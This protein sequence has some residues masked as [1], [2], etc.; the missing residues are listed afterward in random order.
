MKF[1]YEGEN[2]KDAIVSFMKNPSQPAEKSKEP[3][4]SEMESEVVHLTTANFD[5]YLASESSV[6]I[7]FYAPW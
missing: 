5:E 1:N 2:N 4:W 7:M 3:E 6:L